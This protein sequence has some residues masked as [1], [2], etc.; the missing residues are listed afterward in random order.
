MKGA[1]EPSQLVV[2]VTGRC[3]LDGIGAQRTRDGDRAH[4]LPPLRQIVGIEE[5]V[6]DALRW[7]LHDDG[8]LEVEAGRWHQ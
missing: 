6:Q 3:P 7:R 5:R 1:A 4:D 8:L 2:A